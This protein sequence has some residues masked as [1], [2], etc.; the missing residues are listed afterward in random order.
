MVFSCQ[1]WSGFSGVMCEIQDPTDSP[2]ETPTDSP[3]N[4][5][6]NTPTN[7]PTAGPNPTQPPSTICDSNPCQNGAECVAFMDN[8][9]YI[10]TGCQEPW[11]GRNCD[12]STTASPTDAPT[13]PTTTAPPP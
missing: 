11:T 4:A 13:E 1:C 6:T 3:T 10:C 9:N 5:P 8:L 7:P 12:I 2:T